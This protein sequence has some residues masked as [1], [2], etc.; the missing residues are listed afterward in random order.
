MLALSYIVGLGLKERKWGRRRGEEKERGSN[1]GRVNRRKSFL[2]R[3]CVAPVYHFPD[4]H[5]SLFRGL[6]LDQAAVL[7]LGPS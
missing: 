5:P 1:E 4:F 3:F 6:G 7:S 2:R